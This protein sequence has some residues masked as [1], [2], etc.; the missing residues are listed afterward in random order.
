MQTL[1]A[2]ATAWT[3]SV[4]EPWFLPC[5][6][7]PWSGLLLAGRSRTRT[8]GNGVG[9]MVDGEALALAAAVVGDPAAIETNKRTVTPALIHFSD[10]RGISST[11]K[12]EAADLRWLVSRGRPP[13][14]QPTGARARNGIGQGDPV[15]G[16][17]VCRWS[18]VGSH[19]RLLLGSLPCRFWSRP[20]RVSGG[21]CHLSDH[22]SRSF[23]G[24]TTTRPQPRADCNRCDPAGRPFPIARGLEGD[25][26]RFRIERQG[27]IRLKGSLQTAWRKVRPLADPG[28]GASGWSVYERIPQGRVRPGTAWRRLSCGA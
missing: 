13:R 18:G 15:P 25:P 24:P 23:H 16:T 8:L 3:D 9:A 5:L 27:H 4:V 26:A 14:A 1:L 11:S 12:L 10:L 22:D 17:Q 2:S 19:Q 21:R 7:G 20:R 28:G 6:K